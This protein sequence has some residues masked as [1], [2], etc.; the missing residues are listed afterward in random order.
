MKKLLTLFSALLLTGAVAM[1]KP[2]RPEPPKR[3]DR[4]LWRAFQE[5]NDAERKEMR[6][7][8]MKDHEAFRRKMSE[9]VKQIR[10]RDMEHMKKIRQLAADYRKAD[11][12]KKAEIKAELRKIVSE[13]YTKRLNRTRQDLENMRKRADMLDKMLKERE[14]NAQMHIDKLTEKMLT[15]GLEK[16]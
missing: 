4:F 11:E 13:G 12:A 8:Q 9:K 15:S 1:D 5:M 2:E 14:K 6:Q 7:L 10:Q 3:P 16:K